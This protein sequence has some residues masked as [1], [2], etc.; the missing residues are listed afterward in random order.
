MTTTTSDTGTH[1]RRVVV[2]RALRQ[3]VHDLLVASGFAPWG[4]DGWIR[5]DEGCD[6]CYDTA[7]ALERGG[8]T[9]LHRKWI[10]A[11]EAMGR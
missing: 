3:A 8:F 2:D 7:W 10:D 11:Q 6:T 4:H 9:H 1:A 5:D